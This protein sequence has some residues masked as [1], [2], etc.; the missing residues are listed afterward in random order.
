MYAER[1]VAPLRHLTG[2]AWR[3]SVVSEGRRACAEGPL[4]LCLPQQETTAV[5]D[6]TVSLLRLHAS[7]ARSPKGMA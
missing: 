5:A 2:Y 4:G 1:R 3:V 6:H 7:A